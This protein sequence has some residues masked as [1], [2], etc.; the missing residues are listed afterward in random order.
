MYICNFYNFI[1]KILLILN[2]LLLFI[3]IFFLKVRKISNLTTDEFILKIH[4]ITNIIKYIYKIIYILDKNI[5]K[6]I[7]EIGN[8]HKIFK[9]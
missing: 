7:L 5:Y 4:Y 3:Y 8:V 6:Y 1:I 9:I 2:Y